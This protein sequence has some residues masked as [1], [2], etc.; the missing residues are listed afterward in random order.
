MGVLTHY[1]DTGGHANRRPH[2]ERYP[3]SSFI[4]RPALVL[5]VGPAAMLSGSQ[6]PTVMRAARAV[7]PQVRCL[8][9]PSSSKP[10]FSQNLAEGPT[11]DDFIADRV[12]D[13]VVLGNTKT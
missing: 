12:P 8:A 4:S 2:Y 5:G 9:T 7:R 1:D 10:H 3:S 11:L 13:R 6:L